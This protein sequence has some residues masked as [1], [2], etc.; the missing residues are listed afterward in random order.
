M[1]GLD[2]TSLGSPASTEATVT[3]GSAEPQTVAVRDGVADIAL[4]VPAEAPDTLD[5]TVA[6]A[7]GST[8][9]VP[10][11]VVGGVDVP[12]GPDDGGDGEA[13]PPR[14]PDGLPRT[15]AD[16]AWMGGGVLAALAL[17]TLGVVLRRRGVR[18]AD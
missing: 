8:A 2:L 16:T 9:T 11:R 15:G 3:V 6:T 14:G 18:Q 4:T 13:V 1:S 17:L 5:I 10:V 7:S 12:S